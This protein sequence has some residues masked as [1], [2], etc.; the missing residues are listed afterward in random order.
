MPINRVRKK[1]NATFKTF[2]KVSTVYNI[3]EN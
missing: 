2:F 1:I 3:N